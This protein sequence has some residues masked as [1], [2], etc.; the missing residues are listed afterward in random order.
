M[1]WNFHFHF[2]QKFRNLSTYGTFSWRFN[3]W[4]QW[5]HTILV[6]RSGPTFLGASVV[7]SCADSFGGHICSL[8]EVFCCWYYWGHQPHNIPPTLSSPSLQSYSQMKSDANF[9]CITN[10]VTS[11]VNSSLTEQKMSG[12]FVQNENFEAQWYN[13]QHALYT[14]KK[15]IKKQKNKFQAYFGVIFCQVKFSFRRYFKNLIML[16]T[17][18]FTNCSILSTSV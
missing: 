15:A 12:I 8:Y 6:I 17:I 2:L 13:M 16:T 11:F 3:F 4:F 1:K 14:V 9:F 5:D 18:W 10:N 7:I